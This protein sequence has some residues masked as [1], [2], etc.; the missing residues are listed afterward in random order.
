MAKFIKYLTGFTFIII[1]APVLALAG[2]FLYLQPQLPNVATL[3]DIQLKVPLRIYSADHKL[4]GE[5]GEQKR[6]PIAYRDIPSDFIN[7]FI[8]AEDSDFFKHK[9]ISIKGF[10]RA[11]SQMVTGSNVQTGGST[12]TMQV[13]K[14]YFLTPERKMIRKVREL[15]L[16]LQIEQELSKEQIL[17]LYVNKIFLG[18]RAYG[19]VAAAQVYY[20]KPVSELT[21]EQFATIAGLPKAPSEFNPIAD[22]KRALIRRDWI[23]SRMLRL[24][25]INQ[26]QYDEAVITP[27]T[28]SRHE[29]AIE[30]HAPY[31]A[32][33][34]RL[35]VIKL[36]G[37]A[38][39]D[40]GLKVY[41]TIDSRLQN[42]AQQAVKQGLH[43]YDSRHGFRKPQHIKDVSEKGLQQ[44]FRNL[45]DIPPLEA[46]IVI[47]A[48]D[49]FVVVQRRN[50]ETLQLGWSVFENFRPY[51]NENRVGAPIQSI[52]DIIRTGDVL[53]IQQDAQSNWLVSQVPQAE[54]ALISLNPNN[55][56][57]IALV[58]G[59]DFYKSKFNRV[60]QAERQIG[61]NIKPFVYAAGLQHGMTA[62][63]IINDA[64]IVIESSQMEEVWRPRNAGAFSGPTRLRSALYQ[65]KNLVSVRLLRQVGISNTIN[66]LTQ[67]GFDRKKL[68][69]DLSLALGSPSF[70]PLSVASAYAIFANGGYKIEPYL[71][72]SISNGQD[73]IIY[74]ASPYT[75]CPDC[76]SDTDDKLEPLDEDNI[77]VEN[78]APRVISEDVAFIIDNIL[79]DTI[80]F[81]TA[82]RAR[83]M[84][85]PDISGKTGTTNGPT[86]VW[87]TGYHPNIVTTT[88]LG[89]NNNTPL[90]EN[91]YG[92]SATLP[93]WIEFMQEALRDQP[94][95]YREQPANVVSV[96]IDKETGKR[97]QPGAANSM[98]EYIQSSAVEQ[99][100]SEP[101]AEKSL[102]TSLE[103][104]F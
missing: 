77:L 73:K 46:S 79:K 84:Q 5:F 38:A 17:E 98:F 51:I 81:G 103:D 43:A 49:N 82:T 36:Y 91:E 32:E 37:T 59:Y 29:Q 95:I 102:E 80:R 93:I 20:G 56:A 30:L 2:A 100:E 6:T 104:I 45:A 10:G 48:E 34:A 42:I 78:I 23:L 33:M 67:F 40:D 92:A 19:I 65:S 4:I 99:L 8:A 16:A 3:T 60:T 63:T 83:A 24:G 21:L 54:A 15:F 47:T 57:M 28:A 27:I 61:S 94:I 14:N 101:A 52:K 88:W 74:Q 96:L 22:P 7:A 35:E 62:A 18:H 1:F 53:Y 75:V 39:Y 89:F 71:I 97:A 13:A 26:E 25:Y 70:T 50:N 44:A 90:G 86:D 76:K 85:R 68:P 55:G 41:T 11:I 9:G 66:Y 64:P 58:G 31:I 87:F 12:I 72:Q 69:R